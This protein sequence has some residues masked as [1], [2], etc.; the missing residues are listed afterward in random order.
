MNSTLVPTVTKH[1][2]V[3]MEH[4]P[5]DRS[6]RAACL[7]QGYKRITTNTVAIPV[8]SVVACQVYINTEQRPDCERTSKHC[9][10]N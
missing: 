7:V 5:N 8:C 9:V 4:Q 10:W 1:I 6:D 3:Y 2:R